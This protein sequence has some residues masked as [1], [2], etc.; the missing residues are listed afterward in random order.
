MY[1]FKF[2]DIGEGLH[3]GKIL[4]LKLQ[5]GDAVEEGDILA[6]VETDKVVAEIPS[7]KT[8][9]LR[10]FGSA[11]GQVI[12]VGDPFAYIEVDGTEVGGTEA[13]GEE[14][15]AEPAETAERTDGD[16]VR[17]PEGATVVGRLDSGGDLLPP[18]DEARPAASSDDG[19]P[20][21]SARRPPQPAR[22]RAAD[23]ALAT[24]AARRLARD[25]SVDLGTV[26]GTGEGGR[27]SKDDIYRA[28]EN[29]AANQAA[30]PVAAPPSLDKDA[31][32]FPLTDD[33]LTRPVDLPAGQRV[34]LTILRKTI[35]RNMEV[36][37]RIPTAIV[38]D[39]G[40]VDDLVELRA[41]ANRNR[42]THISYQP[43]FM[44]AL[45]TALRDVPVLNATY[46]AVS[47]EVTVYRE[48]N[49][50]F[51][52]N[53]EA[54]V[55]LPVIRNVD[56]STILT[57]DGQMKQLVAAA[58]NRSLAAED[59]R[60]GTIAL[61]NFGPF[62]GLWAAPMIFPPQVAILGIGRIHQAPR[63][64]AGG[65]IEARVVVPVSLA[66]DHRVVDGVPAATFVSRFLELL[67]SPQELMV[68]M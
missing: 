12:K 42:T 65:A 19:S 60:G 53:T 54:G 8:G 3:E 61:T 43:F 11:A 28:A 55:L 56:S 33:P 21:P 40:E 39:L 51:A 29:P 25:L 59:L 24:P 67:C 35:A 57:L 50:G 9:V 52:V 23:A 13:D 36:S 63:V 17:P 10:R 32:G 31:F 45:A 1:E 6:I 62:G 37:R 20:P 66:F 38:H 5:P 34:E 14:N 16:G 26:E 30:L 68:S 27:I 58:R 15:G 18:S 64:V 49:V 7:P 47:Q 4:E 44:K 46:D 2:P 22:R 41:K 48:V